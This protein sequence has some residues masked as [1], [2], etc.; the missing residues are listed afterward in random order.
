MRLCRKG[1]CARLFSHGCGK[2]DLVA[3]VAA[4]ALRDVALV[5]EAVGR[6]RGPRGLTEDD[7]PCAEAEVCCDC[8]AGAF[9]APSQK[10]D[11]QG[12]ARCAERQINR[13]IW[14]STLAWHL[15]YAA[16][17][18]RSVSP[19]FRLNSRSS[20]IAEMLLGTRRRYCQPPDFICSTCFNTKPMCA[21]CVPRSAPKGPTSTGSC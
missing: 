16:M 20:M 15:G 9:A 12:T 11:A 19:S 14:N 8:D 21:P 3:E 10:V 1:M 5:R 7:G 2:A 18:S 17:A 4:S 6:G 13:V